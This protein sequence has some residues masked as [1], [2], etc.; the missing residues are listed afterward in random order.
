VRR[1]RSYRLW[2]ERSVHFVLTANVEGHHKRKHYRQCRGSSHFAVGG[3]DW[4]RD[5]NREGRS[6]IAWTT[7]STLPAEIPRAA[8]CLRDVCGPPLPSATRL[9]SFPFLMWNS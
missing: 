1:G 7:Q 2:D 5:I 9:Q 4:N 3:P 6:L 8:S